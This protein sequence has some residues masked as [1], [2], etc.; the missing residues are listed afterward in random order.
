MKKPTTNNQISIDIAAA[1]AL[2][3]LTDASN[4]QLQLIADAALNATKLLASQAAEADKVKSVK[5][6]DDHDALTT[7][8]GSVSTLNDRLTEK[9]NDLKA[10]IK[11]LKDGTSSQIAD[12]GNRI[13]TIERWKAGLEGENGLLSHIPKN[14]NRITV[15]EMEKT[16]QKVT[17]GIGIGILTLLVSLLIYHLFQV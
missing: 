15:L 17:M 7:L 1:E 3:L 8:I 14:G 9:F 12:H 2:K 5:G 10:D 11:D 6:V 4:K 16:A 13:D